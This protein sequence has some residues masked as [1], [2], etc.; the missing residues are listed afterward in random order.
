MHWFLFAVSDLQCVWSYHRP[1]F[2]ANLKEEKH[3][4]LDFFLQRDFSPLA[5]VTRPWC[6]W[7]TIFVIMSTLHYWPVMRMSEHDKC[8][9]IQFNVPITCYIWKSAFCGFEH[10][11]CDL[12]HSILKTPVPTH[13]NPRVAR[14]KEFKALIIATALFTE[15]LEA[16]DV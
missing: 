14:W 6:P 3:L 8:E 10:V 11:F 7:F 16:L 2:D 12:H 9:I 1:F 15:T 5:A 13:S 4:V